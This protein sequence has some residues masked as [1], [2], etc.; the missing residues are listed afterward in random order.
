MAWLSHHELVREYPKMPNPTKGI[1]PADAPAGSPYLNRP[2]RRYEDVAPPRDR[3]GGDQP[4]PDG[5][6]VPPAPNPQKNAGAFFTPSWT[7]PASP[8]AP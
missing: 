4:A 1:T 5:R 7:I 2:L 8:A 3:K 6:P